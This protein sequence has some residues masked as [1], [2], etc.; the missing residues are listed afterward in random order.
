MIFRYS[1]ESDPLSGIRNPQSDIRNWVGNGR[2][3]ACLVLNIG[4]P[5][6]GSSVSP[7]EEIFAFRRFVA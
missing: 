1:I 7:G 3:L 5:D 4:V 2:R 6:S